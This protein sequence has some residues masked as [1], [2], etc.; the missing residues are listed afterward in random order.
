MCLSAD[1]TL[2]LMSGQDVNIIAT[3]LDWAVMLANLVFIHLV[4]L[5]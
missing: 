3:L 1:E 2:M 4:S 5:P